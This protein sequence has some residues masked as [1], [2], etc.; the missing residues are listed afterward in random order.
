M[1][2][3]RVTRTRLVPFALGALVLLGAALRVERLGSTPLNFDESFTAMAGRLPLGN[4]FSFLRTADSHPPLDYLLQLPLARLGANPFVF[5]LPAAL[6]SIAALALFAWWMRD[7][8]R[9]GVAATAAMAICAFQ[10]AYGREARMYGPMELIGVGTAV[11]A[12]SWLRN[13]RRAHVVIIGALTFVGLMTHISMALMAVGLL[14]LPGLRRDADAWRWRGAVAIGAA[15]WALLWGP[16][17]LV[18]SRGGHSSW[19]PH[20]TPARFLATISSLVT[21]RPGISALVVA[22]VVAGAIV[23]MRRD[24]NLAT[25]L[26]CCSAIPALLAGILGLHAPVLLNRTLTVAAWG[27][28]LA[29][30]FLVD[31]AFR[32]ARVAGA[33]AAATAALLMLSSV[34]SALNVPGP[35]AALTELDRVARPGDVIAIQPPSKGV[36]LYW[37]IGVRSDD[38]PARAVNIAGI[39]DAVALA[40]T[41]RRPTGR[42]WLMQ[43]SRQPINLRAYHLC[44]HTWH[45]GASRMLCI[46]HRYARGFPHS[47][48]PNIAAIYAEFSRHRLPRRSTTKVAGHVYRS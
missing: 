35:T 22:A 43:L 19:I 47:T 29:I 21:S 45:D 18:Q 38:G 32:R 23:C 25:V 7:R 11:V 48:Q 27:P 8:G 34:P 17:F 12:E 40:L 9:V 20:T 16:S 26:V 3:G 1:H 10:I 39:H 5:R 4:M 33:V 30:G 31:A 13:P 41:A 24:R 15:G 44:A 42:V 37:T 28:L 36:E 46:R 14:A 2:Q 6:C